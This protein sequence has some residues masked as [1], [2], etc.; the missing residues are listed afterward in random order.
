MVLGI[1]QKITKQRKKEVNGD[2]RKKLAASMALLTVYHLTPFIYYN[3]M[4]THICGMK[5]QETGDKRIY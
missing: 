4:K 1:Q 3:E 5:N 2:G